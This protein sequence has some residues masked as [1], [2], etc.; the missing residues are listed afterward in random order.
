MNSL[1]PTIVL[2]TRNP[3]KVRELAAMLSPYGIR[4][5][6]TADYPE[7]P[8]IVEDGTTF[9]EN[10]KKKALVVAEYTGLPALADDSGL[11]VKALDG[12]PGVYSARFA[13]ENATDEENNEKLLREMAHIPKEERKA[14]FVSVIA[15]A[16]P[17]GEVQFFR[18]EIEGEVLF[19]PRGVHGFGYDP[20]FYI[21][22]EGKSMAELA[23]D[24]KNRISH[25]AMAYHAFEMALQ[26][27]L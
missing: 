4:I 16:K 13:G 11:C 22:S 27:G 5:I 21:P 7:L 1:P 26:K 24:E 18:G 12:R 15:Y 8:D 19:A 10:A 20:L 9:E 3:H 17:T 2:A 14:T 23:P 6:S 25:R